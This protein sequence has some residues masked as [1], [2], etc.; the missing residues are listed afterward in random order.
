[1]IGPISKCATDDWYNLPLAQK[2]NCLM[3]TLKLWRILD[4]CSP[5]REK[6]RDLLD[7]KLKAGEN[8]KAAQKDFRNGF[9]GH[10]IR[11]K[12]VGKRVKRVK[13]VFRQWYW[14]L[15]NARENLFT[16]ISYV[17]KLLQASTEKPYLETLPKAYQLNLLESSCVGLFALIS[18]RYGEVS[19]EMPWLALPEK[20]YFHV[21]FGIASNRRVLGHGFGVSIIEAL[22]CSE[23]GDD[24][25][26][27]FERFVSHLECL[28]GQL[29]HNRLLSTSA[30]QGS[31]AISPDDIY[32]FE[33]YMSAE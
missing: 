10:F 25:F 7:K 32:C 14:A 22:Q 15:K 30:F 26:R 20:S 4:I 31:S 21:H 27:F 18:F 1:M 19:S 17:E 12:T 33:R 3:E 24:Y 6:C 13:L 11:Y 23:K 2:K 5:S 28:A 29:I 8:A 16:S 9:M